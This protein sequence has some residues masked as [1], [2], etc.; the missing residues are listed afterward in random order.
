MTQTGN[1]FGTV[2]INN[3]KE[4]RIV[5]RLA[6]P[7]NIP[8]TRQTADKTRRAAYRRRVIPFRGVLFIRA[9]AP[10]RRTPNNNV[11]ARAARTTN[12][13]T[14]IFR[15]SCVGVYESRYRCRVRGSAVKIAERL[16]TNQIGSVR[17]TKKKATKCLVAFDNFVPASRGLLYWSAF[18]RVTRVTRRTRVCRV[19][20]QG[21]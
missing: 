14:P 9:D 1:S 5:T 12:V 20:R 16:L 11:L 6:R 2:G 19:V 8:S 4:N 13:L 21:K 18:S 17:G 10:W 3:E 7:L 15:R